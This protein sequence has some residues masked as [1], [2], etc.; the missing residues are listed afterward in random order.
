MQLDLGPHPDEAK[1]EQY[2][3]GTL[4]EE[5]VPYFEEHLLACRQCQDHLLEI[6]A[7]I[8]AVR[9][10][11]P[12]LRAEARWKRLFRELAERRKIL[13]V[14]TAA[15]AVTLLLGRSWFPGPVE[16][17]VAVTL[18]ARRGIEGLGIS[19]APVGR[20]LRLIIDLTE[21]P[22]LAAYSLELV[23][24]QGRPRWRQTVHAGGGKI[25][26]VP[27]VRL[28]RGPHFVRLYSPAQ[29]LMREFALEVE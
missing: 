27:A 28:L 6:D 11:S 22:A 25:Q 29:K 18:E 5:E 8:A 21:L 16:P 12:R 17:P 7:Y 15:A 14:A 24:A 10:V 3:M 20:P 2:S 1:L 4:T 23:D 26:V 13:G 9:T 19:R